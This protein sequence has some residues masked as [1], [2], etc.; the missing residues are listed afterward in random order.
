MLTFRTNTR[1]ETPGLNAINDVWGGGCFVLIG[2]GLVVY[3]LFHP[4]TWKTVTG[5]VVLIALG[6]HFLRR[7]WRSV[8]RLRDR[9]NGV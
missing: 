6:L 9:L 1:R 2:A 5:G 8:R 7:A 3:W 4:H